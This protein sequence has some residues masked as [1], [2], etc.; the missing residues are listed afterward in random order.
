MQTILE[1]NQKSGSYSFKETADGTIIICFNVRFKEP[2]KQRG[3]IVLKVQS[4]SIQ[5]FR[6]ADRLKQPHE[7]KYGQEGLVD[8]SSSTQGGTGRLAERGLTGQGTHLDVTQGGLSE[9]HL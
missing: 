8:S 5:K 9:G 1:F 6:Q 2:V 4:A 7:I 3:K